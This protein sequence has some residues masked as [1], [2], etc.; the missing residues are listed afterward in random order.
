MSDRPLRR[1]EIIQSETTEGWTIYES[2]T[3]SLHLL[4]ASAKAIWDLCDGATTPSEMAGAISEVTGVP[5]DEARG[6]VD[7]ALS[8][9][10][11]LGLIAENDRP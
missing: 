4:N 6:D 1:G 5:V 2:S 10:R 9:L 7:A 11:I 8:Q 3:D